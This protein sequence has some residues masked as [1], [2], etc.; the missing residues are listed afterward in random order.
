[1]WSA[2]KAVSR[3]VTPIA[4]CS[5]GTSFSSGWCGAWSVAMHSIVPSRR[6]SISAWRSA[7]RAQR[8][9]HLEAVRVEAADL[10]VGEAEVVRAGLGADLHPGGLGGADDLDRL[11]GGEVLD[12]DAGVLVGGEGG[13]AGDHRR[14]R[15]RGDAGEAER[16]RDRALVHD[17]V[18]GELGVLLVQGDRAAAEA[19]V[20]ERAAHHPGAADRQAVVGEADRAGFAQFDHLG[21]LL[22]LHAAGDGGEEADRD[23]GAGARLLAQGARR[24]PAV[25]TGGSVLAIARI[26]Q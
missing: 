9:V 23:R 3:P 15:D 6:P 24:R 14:L 10:L 25:E 12:V 21:Q 22:A 19:L 11:G 26:P 4:A 2:A 18:A 16:R 7:S 20:L 8:R 1:M 17:A 5:K 13:V